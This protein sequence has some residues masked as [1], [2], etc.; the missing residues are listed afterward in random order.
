MTSDRSQIKFNAIK[1][2][3]IRLDFDPISID[4]LKK[5]KTKLDVFMK[6]WKFEEIN[7]NSKK[8]YAIKE[9]S[10]IIIDKDFICYNL[11]NESYH[12]FEE[13]INFFKDI[14]TVFTEETDLTF[15]R[16]GLR[17]KNWCCL[18]NIENINHY[19]NEK[20]FAI[21]TFPQK[22]NSN[23]FRKQYILELDDCKS[24]IIN[25]IDKG[26][27]ND[28]IEAYKIEIDID[29]ILEDT[30]LCSLTLE[31][32]NDKIANLNEELFHIFMYHLNSEF[33]ENL[34]K[35][36]YIIPDDLYGVE[37]ND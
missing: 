33:V 15:K 9:G 31:T 6:E 13:R 23:C 11:I 3:I 29:M 37:R 16:F 26:K 25:S 12:K 10:K 21:D 8:E 5:I 14:L 17:K 18:Y 19:F 34:K 22:W 30:K 2:I 36:D 32:F 28:E 27:I 24:L 35:D 4:A 1:D 20:L 7:L